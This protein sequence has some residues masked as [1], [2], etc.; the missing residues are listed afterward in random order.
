MEDKDGEDAAYPQCEDNRKG[1]YKVGLEVLHV[2]HGQSGLFVV[3]YEEYQAQ[4]GIVAI[5]TGDHGQ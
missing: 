2:L 4:D 5:H 3:Y 1:Y